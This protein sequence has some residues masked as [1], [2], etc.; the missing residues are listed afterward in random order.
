MSRSPPD[1]INVSLPDSFDYDKEALENMAEKGEWESLSEMVR[2]AI[3][4]LENDG[5]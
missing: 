1:R 4:G 2:E 5:E 3:R